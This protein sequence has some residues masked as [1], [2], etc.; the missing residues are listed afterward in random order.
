MWQH[1]IEFISCGPS[2]WVNKHTNC[3]PHSCFP[4][5]VS[6]EF[7]SVGPC[8]GT[9]ILA[10]SSHSHFA[11][12]ERPWTPSSNTNAATLDACTFSSHFVVAQSTFIQHTL[13]SHHHL[14]PVL[15][16]H[17]Y[18]LCIHIHLA[19]CHHRSMWVSNPTRMA[20]IEKTL[21]HQHILHC[22]II[23][24]LKSLPS[25]MRI[26]NSLALVT[27]ITSIFTLN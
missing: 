21:A 2:P 9:Q 24:T 25:L 16:P 12:S 17:P 18:I 5:H 10:L 27:S 7:V 4:C 3:T 15:Q 20:E 8:P 26:L 6:V 23:P 11:G 1:S 13:S 22:Q 19:T 14:Y